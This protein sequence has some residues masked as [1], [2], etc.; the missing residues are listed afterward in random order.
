MNLFVNSKIEVRNSEISG[1]GVFAKED[2]KSGEILEEC[3]HVLLMERFSKQDAA[4]KP[5]IFSWPK[6]SWSGKHASSIVLGTGSVYNHRDDN[7]ADWLT[8]QER[9]VYSFYAIKDI[10]KDEEI[11]TNY[12][13]HYGKVVGTNTK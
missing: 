2:I 11:F 12:G 7:N 9:N 10:K 3:H 8:D 1:R 13:E 4:L 5:Y 6:G